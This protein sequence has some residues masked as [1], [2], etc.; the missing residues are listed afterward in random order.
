MAAMNVCTHIVTTKW[1][2]TSQKKGIF[3]DETRFHVRDEKAEKEWDFNLEQSM[4]KIKERGKGVLYGKKFALTANV[5][6]APDDL[7]TIIDC[8]GG[9]VVDSIDKNT[10]VLSCPD[11]RKEYLPSIKKAA[12]V[13]AV[14]WVMETVMR[15]EESDSKEH[16]LT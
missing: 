5:K 7:K 8:A 2:E 15:Q 14:Q 6:P 11:D 13:V 16:Q 10:I 12:K 3:V 4:K 1:L 9:T